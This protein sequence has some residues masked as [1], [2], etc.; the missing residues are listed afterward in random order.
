MR[1]KKPCLLAALAVIFLR[2]LYL[3]SAQFEVK[4]VQGQA[5]LPPGFSTLAQKG[6]YLLLIK[7]P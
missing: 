3:H 2:G 1:I 7:C 4:V 6:D 5:D